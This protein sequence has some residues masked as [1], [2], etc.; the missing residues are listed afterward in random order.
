MKEPWTIEIMPD[1]PL[2]CN[3]KAATNNLELAPLVRMS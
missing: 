1:P 3:A 2:F